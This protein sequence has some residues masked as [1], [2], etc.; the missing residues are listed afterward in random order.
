MGK[1]IEFFYPG[2]GKGSQDVNEKIKNA[3]KKITH[4]YVINRLFENHFG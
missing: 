4:I 2:A 3:L 1:F